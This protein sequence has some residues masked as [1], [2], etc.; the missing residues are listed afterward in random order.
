MTKV[1]GVEPR[2]LSDQM[3]LKRYTAICSP[4]KTVAE[5][6]YTWTALLVL[7]YRYLPA[8]EKLR[9]YAKSAS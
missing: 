8:E 1:S 9:V 3:I 6:R 5:N 7:D 4:K 2:Q